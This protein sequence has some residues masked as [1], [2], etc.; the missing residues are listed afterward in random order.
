MHKAV[1][2]KAKRSYKKL[3]AE[4]DEARKIVGP[5]G[6]GLRILYLLYFAKVVKHLGLGTSTKYPVNSIA[7]EPP[8]G[9]SSNAIDYSKFNR[10][11]HLFAPLP[12]PGSAT[13]IILQ[14]LHP[15]SL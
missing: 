10:D 5:A 6:S 15:R 8:E 14:D 9:I 4:V 7:A 2:Y 11:H 1:S 3:K 13:Y 12:R